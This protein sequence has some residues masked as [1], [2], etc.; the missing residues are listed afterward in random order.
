MGWFFRPGSATV[1]MAGELP[2]A[3][4]AIGLY[5]AFVTVLTEIKKHN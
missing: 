3:P 1:D 5:K 2:I 4:L